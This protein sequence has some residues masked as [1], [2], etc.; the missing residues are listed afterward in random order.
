MYLRSLLNKDMNKETN[1]RVFISDN[2]KQNKIESYQNLTSRQAQPILTAFLQSLQLN[3]CLDVE[4]TGLDAW[5]NKPLIWLI[6]NEDKQFAIEHYLLDKDFLIEVFTLLK[7]LRVIGHNVKFDIKFGYTATNILLTKVYDTM[8]AEQRLYQKLGLRVGL[9]ALNQRYRNVEDDDMD[10]TVRMEFINAN[11]AYFKILERHL[12]YGL[13]D[14]IHLQEIK[15]E[16]DKRIYKNNL[17]NLIYKIEFPLIS[18]LAKAE[19]TGFVFNIEKWN[20]IA[21]DNLDKKLEIEQQMDVLFRELRSKTTHTEKEKLRCTG[22]KYD[23]K[24]IL[25]PLYNFFDYDGTPKVLDLFGEASTL[26]AVTGKKSKIDFYPKD[27]NYGSDAQIVELFA[28]LKEELPTKDGS[29]DIPEFNKKGKIDKTYYS[30]QT[31]ETSLTKYKLDFPNSRMNEF[32]DVLLKQRSLTT[33]INNFGV[34]YEHK[35]NKVTGRLH[36]TYRQA[37]AATGRLQSGGGKNEP[38]KPNFQNIPADKE[39]RSCFTTTENRSIITADY[40]GAELIVM[41]SLS[42]DMNLLEMSKRDMHSEIATKCYRAVYTYRKTKFQTELDSYNSTISRQDLQKFVDKYEDL[43]NNFTVDKSPEK[44]HL[45]TGFKP[46][47][48]GVIYGLRYKAL[49]D[50]LSISEEEAKEIIRVIEQNF[51][52]VIAYVKSCAKF[53][54]QNGYLILNNRTKDRVYFPNIIKRMKGE[55][56]MEFHFKEIM[57]DVNEAR[58]IPIQGTQATAI[59]E[60]TVKLQG[61]VDNRNIDAI[62]LNFVHDEIITDIA[63][64]DLYREYT[65]NDIKFNNFAEVKSY[66]MTDTFNKYLENVEIGVHYHIDKHW[67]K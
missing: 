31:N 18:I 39:M 23:H 1:N 33:R 2:P 38:D 56:S 50:A 44:E 25:S 36:T 29:Y 58:N 16:Q 30:F 11:P 55:M 21:K 32:I 34:K 7:G 45:R 52:K 27:I 3:V 28:H 54:E 49:A 35:L 47:T 9:S 63:D 51:P 10:K 26:K 12:D 66:I 42:Q 4:T 57:D 53:A 19:V 5:T 59:K 41:C 37:F 61:F 46:I 15:R 13:K 43:A 22:G 40:T 65:L 17:Y 62:L 60:A 48:F 8:V 20:K 67:V 6:G 64:K 14:I 24:R